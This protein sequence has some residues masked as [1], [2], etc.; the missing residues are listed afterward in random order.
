[1]KKIFFIL[2]VS[3]LFITSCSKNLSKQFEKV[4]IG[5]DKATTYKIMGKPDDVEEMNDFLFAYWFEGAKDQKDADRKAK[6]G[7]SIKYYCVIFFL[8]DGTTYEIVNDKDY[9]TGFW[10]IN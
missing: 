4:H 3:M 9:F 8:K 7:Y 5:L 10:G 6:D 1:M 2:L